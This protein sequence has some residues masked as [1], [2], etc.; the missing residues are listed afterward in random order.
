LSNTKS[1]TGKIVDWNV[2]KRLFQFIRPYKWQF[3]LLIFLTTLSAALVPLRPYL[4]QSTIDNDVAN[5]DYQGLVDMIYL[6]IGLLIIQAIIQYIHTYLSG[7]IGQ[8]IVKDLR[9]KLYDH[10]LKLR[11]KFYDN[12]PIG[13]LV[14]RVIS[15]IETLSEVFSQG[16]ASIIGDLL[17]LFFIMGFMFYANWK[18]ALVCLITLPILLIATYIFKEK[19]KITFNNV[20]NAV[21]NLNSFVQEHVTGMSIVQIFNSEK[22]EYEKFKKINAEHKKANIKSILYYSIYFPVA[23]IV[24]ATGIALLIWYGASA[25]LAP[26]ETGITLGMLMAFIMYIQLFFRPIR[27]L[28]DRFNT[29]QMG[30]VSTAR[31]IKLLDSAEFTADEGHYIPDKFKGKVEF[32]GIWFAYIDEE[33]VL[34]DISFTV[35]PGE[36]VAMVGAT[37]AGK[38]SI[39]NLLTRLY[40]INRGQLLID[41]MDVR[42]YDLE[43][44]RKHVGIVLQDVF[45]F[46]DTIFNNITLGNHEIS[47]EQVWEAAEMVGARSFIEKMPGRLDYNVLERGAGLSVGQRQLIS[48]VRAMVY[49]PG[50]IILDEATS[51]VDSETEEL[52]KQAIARMMY[53]RTS[54]VIAHRLSTI[55]H[56]DNILVVDKGEIKESGTHESLLALGGYYEQLYH[57]QYKEVG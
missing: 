10:L 46:S 36:T 27:Q 24:A 12:T 40:P 20:R 43:A 57:M 32:E 35:N 4:I 38:S 7:W 37:G 5:G 13:R 3:A 9:I 49:N 41:D 17:Q 48:F 19:I 2:L 23:D 25:A 47:R 54:I 30:V 18:L 31:I 11:L 8:Y 56:A 28:A 53:G 34:K 42:E 45:L 26:A 52:I 33:Y 16:L 1:V 44:L 22:A 6:L 55:Q 39:V 21:A 50:I 29:L 51:S 15:D 14:T